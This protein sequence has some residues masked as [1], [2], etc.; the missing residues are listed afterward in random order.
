VLKSLLLNSIPASGSAMAFVALMSI[1]ELNNIDNL[2][3]EK[4]LIICLLL[5]M[6]E[7]ESL[8]HTQQEQYFDNQSICQKIITR[9]LD[10][11]FMR[12]NQ[13]LGA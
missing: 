9:V 13:G 10:S 8:D 7:S 2:V 12:I 6:S 5:F 1:V 3:F 11:R 4:S